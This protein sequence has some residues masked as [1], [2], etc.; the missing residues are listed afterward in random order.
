M[1]QV[2]EVVVP[3]NEAKEKRGELR[4]DLVEY[5]LTAVLSMLVVA[6]AIADA[7]SSL[8]MVLVSKWVGGLKV[9]KHVGDI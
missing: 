1:E 7:T 3:A 4:L 6:I 9:A 5:V 8:F 2:K